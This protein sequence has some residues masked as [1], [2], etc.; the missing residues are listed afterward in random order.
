[1]SDKRKPVQE[2]SIKFGV[3]QRVRVIEFDIVGT[4]VD[5]HTMFPRTPRMRKARYHIALDKDF[6][7]SKDFYVPEEQIEKENDE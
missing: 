4:I 1:M 6:C 2:Y 7:N 5:I 3:G